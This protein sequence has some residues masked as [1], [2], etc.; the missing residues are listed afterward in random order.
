MFARA[1]SIA[2]VVVPMRRVFANRATQHRRYGQTV[3]AVLHGGQ[4]Q[5]AHILMP[6]EKKQELDALYEQIVSEQATLSDL[7]K[8]HSTCP[9]ASNGGVI[10]WI[11]RG[12]T[13][14]PFEET[15]FST[16][17]GSV[18]QCDTQ[19]GSHI[20]EILDT[21]KPPE[22]YKECSVTD[23]AEILETNDPDDINLIDV[24][25]QNEWDSSCISKFTLKPLSSIRDWSKTVTDDFDTS[26]PTYMLC[27][28]GVRSS[29]AAQVLVDLGFTDVYNV[30]G[31]MYAAQGVKGLV[32]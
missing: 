3:S 32:K 1:V 18:A 8:E 5:V 7:A 26:K 13:V 15:A 29:Q 10:G 22:P 14:G 12:Q 17:V 25:E 31:G 11:Q 23:L 21:R 28:A 24:R 20:I 2:K 9:S 16:P 6:T 27:A 30:T 19:F 4:I